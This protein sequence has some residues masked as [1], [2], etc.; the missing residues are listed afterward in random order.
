MKQRWDDIRIFLAAYRCG[1]CSG[2]S[3]KIGQDQSTISRRLAALEKSMGVCLFDRV[4]EG[5]LPTEAA[6]E[7]LPYAETL[8]A[9]IVEMRDTLA[10]LE[11]GLTGRVRISVPTQLAEELIAPNLPDFFA[12]FPRLSID[13]LTGS[14]VADLARREADVGLRFVQPIAEPLVFKSIA[15]L[16]WGVYASKAYLQQ[17]GNQP[18][19]QM[20]WLDW[21]R[22]WEHLPESVWRRA[23]YP[24]VKLVMRCNSLG[25]RLRA[26][27]A[28]DSPNFGC[29]GFP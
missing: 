10:G 22:S 17:N 7:M 21:D 23:V 14:A 24:E 26:V 15:N 3:G 29:S 5:L 20:S 16:T 2:A 19:A 25:V 12:R 27:C 1:S 11:N 6:E 13:L 28:I 9:N 4:P 8:E 18:V